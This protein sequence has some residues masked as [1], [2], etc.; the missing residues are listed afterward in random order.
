MI[1]KVMFFIMLIVVITK[2]STQ[3]FKFEIKLQAA[4]HSQPA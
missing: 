2:A 3:S 1:K 4:F